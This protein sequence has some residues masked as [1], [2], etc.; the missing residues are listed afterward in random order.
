MHIFLMVKNKIIC[1]ST[2]IL[3]TL[4]TQV[5]Q[6]QSTKPSLTVGTVKA[7]YH[8]VE[9]ANQSPQGMTIYVQ[10]G[11]YAISRRLILTRENIQIQSLSGNRDAVIL[12][13]QGMQQRV[14]TEILLDI[15][16]SNITIAGLTLQNVGNHLIQVRGE[17][18]AD[19]FTLSNCVLRDAYQQLLKVTAN[20]QADS[21]YADNGLVDNCLFEYS[22]GIGPQ[23]YIGGIDA[24]RS[25]NWLV[26]NSVFK[27][28]ASPAKQVAE[29]AIHF[30]DDSA[31]NKVINN[32]IVNCDR[33]IG[34]GLGAAVPQN[35]GGEISGNYILHDAKDHPFADVGIVLESSPETTI[36]NNIIYSM[37]DYPNAIE[38]RFKTTKRVFISNNTVNKPIVSR[39]GAHA[40]IK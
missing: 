37:S 14:G 25:R 27:N 39:D 7:L 16:A 31:N 13:G 6:A 32:L 5:S 36:S 9:Q 10:D 3:I 12:H 34:F 19:N 38:Y 40:W 4:F 20:P 1:L 2:L 21:N 30:W 24:H 11:S 35:L 8:A 22:A 28:I 17:R 15:S 33:G 18:N 23:Y 26:K 29:H